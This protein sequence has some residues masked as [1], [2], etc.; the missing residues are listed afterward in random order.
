M[1]ILCTIFCRFSLNFA[2]KRFP[3]VNSISILLARLA[4]QEAV[5]ITVHATRGSVPREVGTWMAV[6]DG[7]LVETIG[8][9]RLE[10]DAIA[11]AKTLLAAGENSQDP[12]PHS[13]LYRLGPS[14]GQC[15][16]GEVEL[17]YE[18]LQSADVPSLRARLCTQ[19][20]PLALFGGG[21]VGRALVRVLSTLPLSISWID[22]RDEIFPDALPDNVTCDHSD[23]VHAAV[24]TLA[25]GSRVLIM[26]FSHAED[27]DIVAACLT[28]H[29]EHGD[30]PYIGLIGSK[31][32]WASF[33]TRLTARGFSDAELDWVTCPIGI[34]GIADK[35]PEAIA[36]AVAAQLLLL[37][38]KE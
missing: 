31:T 9:G 8:G 30:L 22:S 36:I 15:C 10:W 27:L 32:K 4:S 2:D 24:P 20:A 17:Q 18:R 35:R 12:P 38:K 16:G 29:R 34:A 21:H 33:R 5:L 11:H 3:F 19:E 26:S 23:P 14:L 37:Q 13:V 28:R 7:G 25:S 1:G 6:W